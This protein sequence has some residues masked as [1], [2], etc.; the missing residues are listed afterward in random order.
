MSTGC[1]DH[2]RCATLMVMASFVTFGLMVLVPYSGLNVA[3]QTALGASLLILSEV[4]FWGALASGGREFRRLCRRPDGVTGQR[5][6]GKTVAV[7]GASGGLGSALVAA[8]LNEGA[9]VVGFARDLA[10]LEQVATGDAPFQAHYIDIATSHHI[11]AAVRP[12]QRFDAVIVATGLDVRK[13]F[14][15]HSDQ[16]ITDSILINLQGAIRITQAF[17]PRMHERGVIAHLGGFGDGRLALPYYAVDVATRAG[18]AACCEALN[19]EL[20]LEKSTV[21]LAYLCPAPADTDAERPFAPLWKQLG[22]PVVSPHAVADFVLDAL[23]RRK[24][25]AMMG[26]S[27]QLISWINAISPRSA[28]RIALSRIG[29]MLNAAFGRTREEKWKECR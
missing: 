28:D 27:T 4:L 29:V 7:I 23:L 26:W 8:M 17:L 15:A 10:K 24:E 13:S 9:S 11:Q 3:M 5:F 16:E 19:R 1:G 12:D 22:T 18:V 20:R 6:A 21:R 25:R 14:Q 2:A